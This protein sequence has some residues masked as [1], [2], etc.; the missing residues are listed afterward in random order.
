MIGRA[1]FLCHLHVVIN[2]V[3]HFPW[4]EYVDSLSVLNMLI[5]RLLEYLGLYTGGHNNG[6]IVTEVL[7]LQ[8]MLFIHICILTIIRLKSLYLYGGIC[9]CLFKKKQY[10]KEWTSLAAQRVLQQ[11]WSPNHFRWRTLRK[12]FCWSLLLSQR[13]LER[14]RDFH[15]ILS[16]HIFGALRYNYRL[17]FQELHY[18]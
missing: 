9:W 13:S 11:R 2:L 18:F 12:R 10:A 4:N 8:W 15:S 3:K 17:H 7:C 5:A 6:T 16:F 14:N 1:M